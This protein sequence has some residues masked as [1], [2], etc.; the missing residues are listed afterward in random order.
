MNRFT[1]AIL[2]GGKSNRLGGIDKALIKVDGIPLVQRIFNTLSD[3]ASEVLIVSN[4]S[5]NYLVE[6]RLVNDIH[7]DCG[8]LGGIHSA[9]WHSSHSNVFVVSV[10]LPFA[11]K[12]IFTELRKH[13]FQGTA[14]ITIP[15]HDGLIEPL[16]SFYSKSLIP[17][18]ER[19][20]AD[21]KGHPITELLI[22]SDTHY[23]DL[24]NSF[25]TQMSFFN[26]NTPDDL[27][28]L[29]L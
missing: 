14:E 4:S 3:S 10:D 6:A 9:L 23:L 18:I 29:E 17:K 8:P 24:P 27:K 2:A 1:L 15:R 22:Q 26:V 25:Q 13:H 5:T 19:I 21:G 20:L 28:A 7:K 12:S 11:S 16:Y